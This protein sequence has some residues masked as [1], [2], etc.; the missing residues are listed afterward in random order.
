MYNEINYFKNN[1]LN[2]TSPVEGYLK[3]NIFNNLYDSYKDLKPAK[4]NFSSAKKV[5]TPQPCR[6]MR[7]CGVSL[8]P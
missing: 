6:F 5:K 3:G 7:G 1:K 8:W 4:I 2:L